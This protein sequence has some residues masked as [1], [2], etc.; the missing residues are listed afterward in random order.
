MLS[1]CNFCAMEVSSSATSTATHC[2]VRRV[3]ITKE[4]LIKIGFIEEQILVTNLSIVIL[5]CCV[6]TFSF[7]YSES[8]TADKN[9]VNL[10]YF[11][12]M[13]PC[14]VIHSSLVNTKLPPDDG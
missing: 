10:L 7:S 4:D 5:L 1:K 3:F 2:S 6:A 14:P 12:N 11:Y 9:V 13:R 8:N